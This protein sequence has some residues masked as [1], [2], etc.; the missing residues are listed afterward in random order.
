MKT[1]HRLEVLQLDA[2][3]K[4]FDKAAHTYDDYAILQ[5]MVADE[6]LDTLDLFTIQPR[7]IIDLGSGTGYCAKPLAKLYPKAKLTLC[8]LSE[9]MLKVA[10]Q[11]S[12]R[13][14]D[15]YS[16]LC[17][18][19]SAL[20]FAD[21]SLD[22]IFSSLSFQWCSDLD[23]LFQECRRTLK[24]DGLLIFSSLGP[25]TLKELRSAFAVD[26][27]AP[28]VHDFVDMHDV[29]DALIRAGFAAPVLQ[30]DRVTMTY[31]SM[32]DVMRDLR[33][34]GAAN[35]AESRRR[36]LSPREVFRRAEEKYEA[37]R[38]QG[39]LPATYEIVYAHAFSPNKA[40]PAQDG[41]LVSTFPL[42]QL[43]RRQT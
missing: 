14:L 12:R 40:D 8:D 42:D 33:G 2:V 3:R 38:Q 20:P 6:L 17:A 24:A 26:G 13:W 11:K 32:R 27:D 31:G 5:R 34:I 4:A 23:R 19:L 43:S 10:R 22:L 37:Y 21:H 41:S 36:G 29:G 28:H 25:D 18:N 16:Y 1:D 39:L 7:R 30:T 15:P 9:N 35:K